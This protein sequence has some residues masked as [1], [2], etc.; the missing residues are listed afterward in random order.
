MAYRIPQFEPMIKN[1]YADAVSN[2][3]LSGWIGSSQTTIDFEN[4]IK[5]ITGARHCI[6]TTSGTVAIMLSLMSMNLRKGAVILFPSYTFLAGANACRLLG[7]KVRLVDVKISTT[8]LNPDL[9]RQELEKGYVDCVIFVNQNAYVGDDVQTIR[10]LCESH[11]VMMIE[12]SS[13]A[14]GID[15]AGRKGHVGIFSFSVPKLITTGQG[16]AIITDNDQ[17][18]LKCMAVRDHG[19]NWRKDRIHKEIGGN[20]KFNDILAAYG[21]SQLNNIKQLIAARDTIFDMYRKRIPLYDYGYRSTWMVTYM[22]SRADQVIEALG[23]AGIQAVKYYRPINH[24][25]PYSSV[26]QYPAAEIIYDELVYLPS[27]LTL[28]EKD[29]DNICDIICLVERGRN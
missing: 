6:S 8:C 18:A 9:V 11:R 29:I 17:I 3:I 1:E 22:T 23:N 27:S 24:N 28:S 26:D 25:P 15:G 10:D 20:F 21:L 14:I 7:Y 4:A 16:G 12:D 2:Q 5:R 13:Q 19:D